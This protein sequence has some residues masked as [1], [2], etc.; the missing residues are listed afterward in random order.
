M[1]IHSHV[2][3]SYAIVTARSNDELL[4]YNK[5]TIYKRNL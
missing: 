5:Y 3:G 2:I 1:Q 4:Q